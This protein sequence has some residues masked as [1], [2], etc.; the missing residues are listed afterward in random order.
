MARVDPAQFL[1]IGVLASTLFSS[2]VKH[3]P[4]A[5]RIASERESATMPLPRKAPPIVTPGVLG[6]SLP[7]QWRAFSNSSPWNTPIPASTQL[8]PN[9]AAIINSMAAEASHIRFSTHYTIPLWVVDSPRVP[10]VRVRSD[11]IFDDWDPKHTGWTNIGVPLG[12]EMW[13][14]ANSDG[15]IVIVDPEKKIAW[16]MSH[17]H[18]S[19]DG[20]PECTTFNVWDLTGPGYAEPRGERW[21][22]RGARGSGFPAVAGLLRPEEVEAGEIRHALVFTFTKNRRAERGQLFLPPAA[23]SDGKFFGEQYPIEGMRLQLDP[24]CGEEDFRRWGLGFYARVVARALQKYGMY[25]GDNGGAMA[26][27]VQL[28]APEADDNHAAWE[29][30]LPGLF[31]DIAK[32]PT[33]RFR[34]VHTGE[35]IIK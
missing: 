16:E 30:R 19:A 33:D 7:G 28:L 21:F 1:C 24:S 14:E 17:F 9:S 25:D 18:R 4:K 35:P 10:L 8:H 2:N 13:G 20:T 34:V 11:K 26:V 27:Q 6:N 12:P 3:L 23:R 22:A 29:A 31:K 32:I 15:R 5:V